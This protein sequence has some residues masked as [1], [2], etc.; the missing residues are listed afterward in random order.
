M[1]VD[2]DAMARE[3]VGL[4]AWRRLLVAHV[5]D[6]M[7]RCEGCATQVNAGRRWP[8]NLY[9]VATRAGELHEEWLASV[10]EGD[11]PPGVCHGCGGPSEGMVCGACVR[12]EQEE[13]ER[14]EEEE[15]SNAS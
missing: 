1:A 6:R 8:C 4:G 11:E 12:A 2:F 15:E 3:V 9:L 13:R 5:A 14:E 7:G 10:R